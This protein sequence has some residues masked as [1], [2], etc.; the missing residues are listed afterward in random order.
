[1]AQE[2]KDIV[3]YLSKEFKKIFM[4]LFSNHMGFDAYV[5]SGVC[6]HKESFETK[7][8]FGSKKE[9]YKLYI[10]NASNLFVIECRPVSMYNTTSKFIP[11]YED[12]KVSNYYF[13]LARYWGNKL[14][15]LKAIMVI[16]TK[17]LVTLPRLKQLLKEGIK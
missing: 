8:I 10:S 17:E 5:I 2:T 15:A 13:V 14:S 3:R 1:M 4:R 12:I 9:F 7:T 6:I 16:E 11:P